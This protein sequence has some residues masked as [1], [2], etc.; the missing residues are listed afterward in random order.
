MTHTI[1][2]LPGDGIGPEVMGEVRR[3]IEWMDKRR[4]VSF[5]VKQDL[6]GGCA[7]DAHGTPLADKTMQAA[8]DAGC[9]LLGAVG[10]PKWDNLPFEKKP[11]RG[12]LRLRKEMD[13]F[14]NLR[15]AKCF[16]ALVDASSLK[17]E[18]VRGLDIMIVRELTGG[19]YFGQ[20]RGIE[21]L[22]NG[23]RR[24]VNTQVY[25]TSEIRRV[26]AVAFELARKRNNKVTSLEKRVDR[27]IV[28]V[29][30]LLVAGDQNAAPSSSH[31]FLVLL[32]WESGG[33]PSI[34]LTRH[35]GRPDGAEVSGRWSN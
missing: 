6:V 8:L 22:P 21:T 20:P 10:G 24:G 28:V 9:V 13:L 34:S 16:D 11:E 15:P 5:D 33:G 32:R 14:A 18:L 1:T 19:L 12:L 2:L 27:Y 4:H 30:V 31:R 35:G 29:L 17:P 7:Y 3:V 26:A 25:T 23:E